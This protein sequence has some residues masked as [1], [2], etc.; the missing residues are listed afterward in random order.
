[1]KLPRSQPVSRPSDPPIAFSDLVVTILTVPL[2]LSGLAIDVSGAGLNPTIPQSFSRGSGAG[3]YL[4]LAL[5]ALHGLAIFRYRT[6]LLLLLVVHTVFTAMR[7]SAPST[8]ELTYS[9][10]EGTSHI[11]SLALILFL[12]LRLGG[13]WG[14]Y[15]KDGEGEI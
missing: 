13:F 5:S 8:G 4:G 14:A 10:L 7:L 9:L 3:H 11:V 15:P 2:F 1:M 6:V 12:S